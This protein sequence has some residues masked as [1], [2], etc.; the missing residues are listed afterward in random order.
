MLSKAM[1]ITGSNIMFSSN[2]T[3][4]EE[5]AYA[6]ELGAIINLDDY[7]EVIYNTFKTCRKIPLFYAGNL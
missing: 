6:A 5:Y 2:D 4:A 1:G 7:T 3:P